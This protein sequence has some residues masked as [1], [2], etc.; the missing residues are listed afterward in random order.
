M[1]EISIE[2][3]HG[4]QEFPQPK[5]GMGFAINGL[6]IPDPTGFSGAESDL[7]T[8]GERDA[9]GYLHRNMVATKHPLKLE[10]S[11]V[12]WDWITDLCPLLRHDKFQFTY[13]DPWSG[14]F[15]TI[16]A[17]V[18]DRDFECVWAP[19]N[20]IYIGTLKFSVIEY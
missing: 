3:Y 10:Y 9:T 18:G 8:M 19:E 2:N 1:S 7:D 13:P 14:G 6:A 17:Y 4:L 5:F 15:S 20:G 16:D 12:P 11:N